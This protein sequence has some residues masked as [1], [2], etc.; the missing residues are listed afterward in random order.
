TAAS[1]GEVLVRAGGERCREP[2]VLRDGDRDPPLPSGVSHLDV[3]VLGHAANRPS[4]AVP[5]L[6]GPTLDDP[7]VSGQL[8]GPRAM[9]R[10]RRGGRLTHQTGSDPFWC[11]SV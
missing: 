7:A 8:L 1:V 11:A 2:A 5:W 9:R 4:R 10:R 3:E 6:R